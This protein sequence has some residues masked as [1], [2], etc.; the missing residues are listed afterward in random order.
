VS[1]SES[2]STRRGEIPKPKAVTVVI[3]PLKEIVPEAKPQA[4][5]PVKEVVIKE[6]NNT[7]SSSNSR[8][9][10]KPKEEESDEEE[11]SVSTSNQFETNRD[12]RSLITNQANNQYGGNKS[13]IS[14]VANGHT[15]PAKKKNESDEVTSGPSTPI[16]R[17]TVSQHI[18]QTIIL[19]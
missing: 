4:A 7:T 15:L 11:R 2:I 19:C 18:I 14:V 3:E 16:K 5:A 10:E 6:V 1:I 9:K 13:N 8:K 12:K 17:K